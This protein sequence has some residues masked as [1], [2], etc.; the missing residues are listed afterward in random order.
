MRILII[1]DDPE[2]EQTLREWTPS[3]VRV[4]VASSAGRAIGI[5]NRDRGRV[6]SGIVLDHDLDQRAVNA[7]DLKLCGRDILSSL[8][9]NVSRDVP[10]LVHSMNAA[11]APVMVAALEKT[12]FCVERIPMDQLAED[13][14]NNWLGYVREVSQENDIE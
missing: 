5:L 9:R 12:G 13:S 1:E 3:D 14:F 4:V 6:Y 8:C 7:E 11:R 2:R 10:I